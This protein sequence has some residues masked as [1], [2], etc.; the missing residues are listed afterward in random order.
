MRSGTSMTRC[1]MM[2]ANILCTFIQLD[3]S[4]H[5]SQA[6]SRL[7][8]GR[9]IPVLSCNIDYPDP[10]SMF[11]FSVLHIV[12]KVQERMSDC[13]VPKT[14]KKFSH[15][16][17]TLLQHPWQG[18]EIRDWPG[19]KD[20]VLS[21]WIGAWFFYVGEICELRLHTVTCL[22]SLYVGKQHWTNNELQNRTKWQWIEPR[23]HR[24]SNSQ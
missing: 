2:N 20:L 17:R 14:F 18:K 13:P 1:C 12:I 23:L 9:K 19:L 6:I 15:K 21:W 7:S 3:N 10:E 5:C 11:T 22:A 16:K 24:K 4:K 8:E